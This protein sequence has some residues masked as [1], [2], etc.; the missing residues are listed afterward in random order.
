MKLDFSINDQFFSTC[1]YLLVFSVN[2]FIIRFQFTYSETLYSSPASFFWI[3]VKEYTKKCLKSTIFNHPKISH[4][5]SILNYSAKQLTTDPWH[6]P[7]H[8]T[9][10]PFIQNI[11]PLANGRTSTGPCTQ[12][13]R[14][15][16]SPAGRVC[17]KV[18][19]NLY[20]RNVLCSV[21]MILLK[22]G[23]SGIL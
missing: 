5:V 9:R 22:I 13:M 10:L 3:Y 17:T 14:V 4:Q 8:T 7:P 23:L 6:L 1:K 20:R 15:R 19:I 11:R 18:H 2:F 12:Q 16:P 21:S